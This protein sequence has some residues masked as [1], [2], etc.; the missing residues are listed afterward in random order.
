MDFNYF[1]CC[2]KINI[3]FYS[4]L[5]IYIFKIASIANMH[6]ERIPIMH[7]F[8]IVSRKIAENL[9][10]E[11]AQEEREPEHRGPTPS[12]VMPSSPR[13]KSP[14]HEFPVQ[15]PDR[16]DGIISSNF[17]QDY[18]KSI[19]D[20]EKSPPKNKLHRKLESL[21][22]LTERKLNVTA[23]LA[24]ETVSHNIGELW[25]DIL[26][27]YQC[28]G[29]LQ[30]KCL[31]IL[32]TS[33]TATP[34]LNSPDHLFAVL[35]MVPLELKDL[36]PMDSHSELKLS[37]PNNYKQS[38][39]LLKSLYLSQIVQKGYA[40]LY[41][42]YLLGNLEKFKNLGT[43][44][45]VLQSSLSAH[46]F[47]LA[48][49]PFVC[50]CLKHAMSILT[51]LI[52]TIEF[53][54]VDLTNPPIKAIQSSPKSG[55]TTEKIC[56]LDS[57]SPEIIHSL[58]IWHQ[59]CFCHSQDVEK[60]IIIFI[61]SYVS[62][63]NVQNLM[64]FTLMLDIL[65]L[66][67]LTNG[68]IAEILILLPIF[69]TYATTIDRTFQSLLQSIANLKEIMKNWTSYNKMVEDL[70]S[71]Y[72][73]SVPHPFTFKSWQLEHISYYIHSLSKVCLQTKISY[74][75][76]LVLTGKISH[77][78]SIIHIPTSLID[79][80]AYKD[81]GNI[82][83]SPKI[84]YLAVKGVKDVLSTCTAQ[85]ST[86]NQSLA[87]LGIREIT[88]Q[89][90]KYCFDCESNQ[91]VT[92]L[93][94]HY[95]PSTSILLAS[96]K[97]FFQNTLL[98]IYNRFFKLQTA[99]DGNSSVS[100]LSNISKT[101]KKNE[102]SVL[103]YHLANRIPSKEVKEKVQVDVI[104]NFPHF[105][106]STVRNELKMRNLSFKMWKKNSEENCSD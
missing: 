76:K 43:V 24:S 22:Q 87:P 50:M 36:F 93:L 89:T 74:I 98:L 6:S 18:N 9:I 81:Y 30:I 102:K 84:R 42:H 51:F 5:I 91:Q 52:N 14:A 2:F 27:M 8:G 37:S 26:V 88:L 60:S 85:F 80:T 21:L 100:S 58:E 17:I 103:A 106:Q 49:S 23:N 77:S 72:Q 32:Y 67:S 28:Q 78:K 92:F 59:I 63:Q 19:E 105:D 29:P 68:H 12:P 95:R 11:H 40:R 66:L 15:A 48:K 16:Y 101:P 55:F 20:I 96:S 65:S 46:L 71:F 70:L 61:Q 1:I 33:L 73:N 41:L 47:S 90:L 44:L 83:L 94:N 3:Y 25:K 13:I 56:L 99:G 104:R 64:D 54:L 79:F 4:I 34:L 82:E 97:D 38:N 86:E 75:R 53:Q 69:H 31:T 7:H 39:D 35:H 10:E 62:N 57:L 45:K